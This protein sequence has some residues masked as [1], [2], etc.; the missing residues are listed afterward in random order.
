[1]RA[2]LRILR[3]SYTAT[4]VRTDK[5][6]AYRQIDRKTNRTDGHTNRNKDRQTESQKR[7]VRLLY[8][9]KHET[10]TFRDPS[11]QRSVLLYFGSFGVSDLRDSSGGLL[12]LVITGP[13]FPKPYCIPQKTLNHTFSSLNHLLPTLR[14]TP[15]PT[16]GSCGEGLRARAR[17]DHEG[18][19]LGLAWQ[20]AISA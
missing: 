4:D 11:S 14:T 15:T 1:M 10:K 12:A 16:W 7:P 18:R 20:A 6:H 17:H 13:A 3:R 2:K 9:I 5:K 19:C 8:T